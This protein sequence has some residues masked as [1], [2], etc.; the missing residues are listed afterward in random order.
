MYLLGKEGQSSCPT[1]N[2]FIA[3]NNVVTNQV[4]LISSGAGKGNET[5]GK[6]YS[7]SELEQ[8]DWIINTGAT[9]HI[10]CSTQFFTTYEPAKNVHANLS[11]GTQVSIS[12]IG[13]V[14]ISDKLLLKN[15]YCVPCFK[16]NL[17]FVSQL[18]KDV[19]CCVFL[20]SDCCII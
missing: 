17:I 18:L 3:D 11:N 8:F 16:F 20:R 2:P 15:V 13:T 19:N 9:C 5:Q 14:K 1:P 7:K 12:H 4:N 10:I 6:L